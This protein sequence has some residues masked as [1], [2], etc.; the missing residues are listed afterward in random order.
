LEQVRDIDGVGEGSD[1]KN[2]RDDEE[3][4][5][6]DHVWNLSGK[7]SAPHCEVGRP[8]L[9]MRQ[10]VAHHADGQVDDVDVRTDLYHFW[11]PAI[12]AKRIAAV[13]TTTTVN[14]NELHYSTFN[15]LR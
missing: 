7:Q 10:I 8:G 4:G 6:R 11:G 13:S 12:P 9:E 3:G 2:V 15:G 5:E 14:F 1:D